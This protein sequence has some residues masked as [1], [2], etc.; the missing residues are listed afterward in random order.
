MARAI[1]SSRSILNYREVAAET[2]HVV[3]ASEHLVKS[4]LTLARANG[5]AS[6]CRM[7]PKPDRTSEGELT[8]PEFLAE[9]DHYK[10]RIPL[11]VLGTGLKRLQ[12]DSRRNAIAGI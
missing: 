2:L 6:N 4:G 8:L 5:W 9:L 10:E 7:P 12:M 1:R 3:K 11:A